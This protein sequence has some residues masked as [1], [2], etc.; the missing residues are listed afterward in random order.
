MKNFFKYV[1]VTFMCLSIAVLPACGL[2]A[3]TQGQVVTTT[4]QVDPG[5]TGP[6]VSVPAASLPPNVQKAFA[7]QDIV[8]VPK[9]AIK[10]NSSQYVEISPSEWNQGTVAGVLSTALPVAGALFPQVAPFLPLL[11]LLFQ[12]PRDLLAQSI[13]DL[14]NLQPGA[15]IRNVGAAVGLMHS[16]EDTKAVWNETKVAVPVADLTNAQVKVEA[17]K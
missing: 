4:S 14:A 16:D 6:V 10:A 5:Y 13:Q 1:L 2:L 9:T 15:A 8:V 12:R 17:A 7:G 11:A 3:N